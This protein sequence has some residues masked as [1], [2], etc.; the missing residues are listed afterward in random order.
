MIFFLLIA[1]LSNFSGLPIMD[2]RLNFYYAQ[3][4]IINKIDTSQLYIEILCLL[5]CSLQVTN[6]FTDSLKLTSEDGTPV[7]AR[8]VSTSGLHKFIYKRLIKFLSFHFSQIF[9]IP[10][11]QFVILP[12]FGLVEKNFI[13][14][15]ILYIVIVFVILFTDIQ[16]TLIR[17]NDFVVW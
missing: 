12:P 8:D 9:H 16:L 10:F 17:Y 2:C 14:F 6:Q 7:Y 13:L 5:V 4:L 1:T 15:K 3:V 11:A